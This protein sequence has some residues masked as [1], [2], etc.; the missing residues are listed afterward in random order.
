[1]D[2]NLPKFSIAVFGILAIVLLGY[3][4]IVLSSISTGI[5][6]RTELF[7][8]K[9]SAGNLTSGTATVSEPPKPLPK[10]SLQSIANSSYKNFQ[11]LSD[12]KSELKQ[13]AEIVSDK[14]I[15]FDSAEGKRL[16]EK[17]FIEKIPTIIISGETKDVDVLQKNWSQLGSFEDNN[18]LVLRN[19]PPIYF[20][21]TSG[22]VRGEAS[23]LFLN[24][25][26][27]SGVY[28]V[29]VH[30]LIAERFGVRPLRETA[31]DYN[32]AEGGKLLSDYNI[33]KLP[34]VILS[35]DLNVYDSFNRVW[36]QVGSIEF[37]GNYVFRNL[38]AL[39]NGTKFFDLE[40]NAVVDSNSSIA[41]SNNGI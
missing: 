1:M 36:V 9:F 35:G 17:Y 24:D 40:K 11:D 6:N 4:L 28:D 8:G 20:D 15:E 34:T 14:T 7:S 33:T 19:I 38:S 27:H 39:G 12:L 26:I 23:I 16:V 10:I 3:N 5:D 2:A 41:V 21:I 29:K 30:K 18:V 22:K 31:I 13:F 37:D 25:P 32:S